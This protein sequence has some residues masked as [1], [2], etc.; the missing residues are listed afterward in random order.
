M[1]AEELAVEV[2][3]L[4]LEDATGGGKGAVARMIANDGDQGQMLA[5]RSESYIPVMRAVLKVLEWHDELRAPSH[6]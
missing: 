4:R 1:T 2:Y 3:K 6:G 5:N